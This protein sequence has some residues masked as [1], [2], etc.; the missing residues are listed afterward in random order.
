MWN[1]NFLRFTLIEWIVALV[2]LLV[3]ARFI[4]TEKVVGIEHSLFESI[5]LGGGAKYL[6]TVPLAVWVLYRMIKREQVKADLEGKKAVRP[7]VLVVSIGILVL[8]IVFM[9]SLLLDERLVLADC[10]PSPWLRVN[11]W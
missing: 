2:A 10:S 11:G 8:A 3:I 1:R 4:W 6:L 7:Q 5:G 9:C